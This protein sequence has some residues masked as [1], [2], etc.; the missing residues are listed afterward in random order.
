MLDYSVYSN[1]LGMMMLDY[2][3]YYWDMMLL[4]YSVYYWN[5]AA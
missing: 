4:D 1:N 5:D 2:S 3:V